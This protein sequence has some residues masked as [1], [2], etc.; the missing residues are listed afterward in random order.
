MATD[1]LVFIPCYGKEIKG[2]VGQWAGLRA[3][4]PDEI[5]GGR[6][7]GFLGLCSGTFTAWDRNLSVSYSSFTP[8]FSGL[9]HWV[10]FAFTLL[11]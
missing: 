9:V 10:A 5:K 8:S 3:T 1:I 2:E 6:D 11:N 7:K 4:E